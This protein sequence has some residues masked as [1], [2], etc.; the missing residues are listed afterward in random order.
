MWMGEGMEAEAV[1]EAV[2]RHYTT[3][4]TDLRQGG[5]CCVGTQGA[6]CGGRGD[7]GDPGE[8]VDPLSFYAGEDL[9]TAF[10]AIPSF[11]CGNPL[12]GAALEPGEDVLDLGCGA[13]LDVLLAA[14]RVGPH[15]AVYGLDMTDAMLALA[16][17]HK[18]QAGIPNAHFLRGRI[19]SIPLPANAV[20]VVMSNCVLNLSPDK[21]AA[22]K[23]AFRVLRPGGR[24][25][26][27]DI[28]E[29]E[30]MPEALRA[31]LE[32]WVG[33]IAGAVPQDTYATLL[34]RA[35]FEDVRFE[36]LHVYRG[37]DVGMPD[38][39]GSVAS[40]RIMARRPVRP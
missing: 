12:Q 19:E 40:V 9:A 26:I 29:Y 14:R 10:A 11:G 23:E 33:C 30:P 28:V 37:D 18:R 6:C 1:R 15:G 35:G 16:Q 3:L 7:G 27:T 8:R 39:S 21:E 2:Q 36:T 20:D 38:V 4:V 13:G 34:A 22:L 24:L 17:S 31:S 32:A 5:D 25:S